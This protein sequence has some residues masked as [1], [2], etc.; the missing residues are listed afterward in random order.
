MLV[1]FFHQLKSRNGTY[2]GGQNRKYGF[3]LG[4]CFMQVDIA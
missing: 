2:Q 3:E 1:G 4:I